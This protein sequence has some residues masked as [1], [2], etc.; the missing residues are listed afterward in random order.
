MGDKGSDMVLDLAKHT[1]TLEVVLLEGEWSER[2]ACQH[3]F[4][5]DDVRLTDARCV[6]VCRVRPDDDG[7]SKVGVVAAHQPSAAK[8]VLGR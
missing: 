1:P 5:P 8:A 4:W 3:G 2:G 7:C 6:R